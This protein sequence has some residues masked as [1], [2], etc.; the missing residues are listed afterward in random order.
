MTIGATRY[1]H[2]LKISHPASPGAVPSS[3]D[4]TDPTKDVV[5]RDLGDTESAGIVDAVPLGGLMIVYKERTTW[6][7][8]KIS[9]VQKWRTER[10]FQESGALDDHCVVDF[11]EGKQHFVMTGEDIIVHNGQDRQSVLDK[12]LRHWLLANIDSTNYGRSFCV[13]YTE[14][15]ECWFCFPLSGSSWPNLALVY[16]TID[17][18]CTFRELDQ[19]S[20]IAPGTIPSNT[21][22]PWDSDSASWDSDTT[23]WDTLVHQ[24]FIRRLLQAKPTATKFFHLESSTTANGTPITAYMERAGLDL[25]GVSDSGEVR[26]DRR[27]RRL[28]RGVWLYASGSPFSVQIATQTDIDGALTWQPAATFIPGVDEKVDFALETRLFGIRFIGTEPFEVFAYAVDIEP[29]GG[30]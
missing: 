7:A 24:A 22:D 27:S 14:E 3:W 23:P 26:R 5:M 6:F 29:L 15:H 11:A 1:P 8:Q 4:E 13:S 25:I 21:S 17:G 30:F 2:R 9:G 12:R 10:L 16:N 18:S 19:A 28:I 20:F